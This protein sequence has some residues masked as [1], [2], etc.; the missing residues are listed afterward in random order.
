MILDQP[1]GLSKYASQFTSFPALASAGSLDG[2][3]KKRGQQDVTFT[4]S[5]YGLSLLNPVKLVS[6]RELRRMRAAIA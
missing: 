2:L 6:F 1:I 4:V 3:A 5:G